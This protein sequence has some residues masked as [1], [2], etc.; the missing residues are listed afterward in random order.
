MFSPKPD[1]NCDLGEIDQTLQLEKDIMP[2]IHRCNIACGGHAGTNET[3]NGCV[4]LAKEHG[5][6]VGAHPSYPDK[7]N[8]G[9]VSMEMTSKEF[10]NNLKRQLNKI[11]EACNKLGYPLN[12][13]K[14]HGAMYHDVAY[15]ESLSKS[16]ALTV[17]GLGIKEIMGPPQCILEKICEELEINYV[18]EAFADR[19]YNVEGKLVSRSLE[20]SVI[21][22]IE[23]VIKQCSSLINHTALDTFNQNT[24][25]IPCDSICV[26]SD[27][28]NSVKILQ[29]LNNKFY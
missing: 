25:I 3:I 29:A 11:S 15:D 18:K 5:V 1:L 21:N 28:E 8:F 6:K 19:K 4:A 23:E 20:G 10:I 13:V 2:L 27:T 7:E 9:R 12:Y 16:F 17:K 22:I 24:L 26:H 14:A